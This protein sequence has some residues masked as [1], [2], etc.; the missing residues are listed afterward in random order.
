[1][2]VTPPGASDSRNFVKIVAS[3]GS[4]W[5]CRQAHVA[6]AE[7]DHAAFR[8]MIKRGKDGVR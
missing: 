7:F 8:L 5:V 6:A 2:S 4:A 1:M 3:G